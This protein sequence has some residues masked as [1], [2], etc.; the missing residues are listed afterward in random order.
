MLSSNCEL[1]ECDNNFIDFNDFD[2]FSPPNAQLNIG[3]NKNGN[4]INSKNG[5]KYTNIG[6]C[7]NN[8]LN[9]YYLN[10]TGIN[11]DNRKVID[12]FVIQMNAKKQQ[13][14]L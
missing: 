6:L 12:E 13:Q 4:S 11:N 9:N 10:S 7:Q 1:N 2:Q 3:N 5:I 8:K 14:F